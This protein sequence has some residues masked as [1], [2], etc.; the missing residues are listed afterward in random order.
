M[1]GLF[2]MSEADD[3]SSDEEKKESLVQSEMTAQVA[4]PEAENV[5]KADKPTIVLPVAHQYS[6]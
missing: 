3:K 2:D 5:E 4:V 1:E 6:A